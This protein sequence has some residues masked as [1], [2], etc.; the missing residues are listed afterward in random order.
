MENLKEL[1]EKFIQNKRKLDYAAKLLKCD[2]GDVPEKI[3][4]L[5][6]EIKEKEALIEKLKA[7]R[8]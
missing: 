1:Y 8:R 7:K 2:W 3:A 6:Y 4:E 5:H